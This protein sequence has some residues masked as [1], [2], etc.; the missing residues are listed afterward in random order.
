MKKLILFIVGFAFVASA[1][2]YGHF[3]R[4][5]TTNDWSHSVVLNE[6]DYLVILSTDYGQYQ[7][8][9]ANQY[10]ALL[11]NYLNFV[12]E[13]RITFWSRSQAQYIGAYSIVSS[14]L[15]RTITG[16]CTVIPKPVGNSDSRIIDYKIVR[17]YEE[18]ESSKY[19]AS[20]NADG[21]RLA[22]A[23]KQAGS[24]AVTRVYEFDGSS[25]NQLGE[26]V[27]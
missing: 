19:N 6:G 20:L 3:S 10:V 21:S 2:E 1:A 26:D 27:E 5:E 25:W 4:T 23:L 8:S 16:P 11:C 12:S 7:S 18:N 22:I 14:D 13:K 15:D 9:S 24:N 17:A